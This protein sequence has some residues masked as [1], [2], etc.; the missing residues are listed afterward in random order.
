MYIHLHTIG[1]IG[2]TELGTVTCHFATNRRQF[3]WSIYRWILLRRKNISGKSLKSSLSLFVPSL[4][5]FQHLENMI[6]PFYLPFLTE[7]GPWPRT[8]YWMKFYANFTI[9]HM[10]IRYHYFRQCPVD[11]QAPRQLDLTD[12]DKQLS[13]WLLFILRNWVQGSHDSTRTYTD[14][15]VIHRWF[16]L[17]Y[18]VSRYSRHTQ[19]GW[20]IHRSPNCMRYTAMG[21]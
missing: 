18:G 9:Q 13:H 19:L 11:D 1:L 4:R 8:L 21:M 10:I 7:M 16:Q 5:I 2:V 15:C 20:V 14:A 12:I 6:S 17:H 3:H